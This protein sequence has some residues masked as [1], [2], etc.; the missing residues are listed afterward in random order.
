[1]ANDELRLEIEALR[2]EV[3][4]MRQEMAR[5]RESPKPVVAAAPASN[6]APKREEGITNETVFAISAAVAA[7]LG[8]KAR[9]RTIRRVASGLDSWRVQGRIAI[10]G[11]HRTR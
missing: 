7:F 11:S 9:I 2:R 6:G 4:E 10:Q 3:A 8:K 1:M 5:L